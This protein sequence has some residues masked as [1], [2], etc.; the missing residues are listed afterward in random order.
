MF[1][2]VWFDDW[3]DW[4]RYRDAMSQRLDKQSPDFFCNPNAHGSRNQTK[5]VITNDHFFWDRSME[6]PW[7][8]AEHLPAPF[9]IAWNWAQQLLW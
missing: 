7:P 3:N 5:R 9:G 4:E 6:A 8:I 2:Q 1:I